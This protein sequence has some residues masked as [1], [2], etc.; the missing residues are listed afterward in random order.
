MAKFK[1]HMKT[2]GTT[3][4]LLLLCYLP[5]KATLYSDKAANLLNTLDSLID[6]YPQIIEQRQS[7]I[8]RI[9]IKP[10]P[11]TLQARYERNKRLFQ[12]YQYFNTDSALIYV[13]ANIAIAQQTGDDNMMNLCRI[14]R[15]YI[16]AIIGQ[17]H[18]SIGEM[19]QID[20]DKL[21][22][23]ML[24]EY[25]GQM[26]LLYSRFAEYTDSGSDKRE[27]YY[28]R[29]HFYVDSTMNVLPHENPYYILYKGLKDLRTGNYSSS[30]VAL[31]VYLETSKT[32]NITNSKL[33]YVLS[34]LYRDNN[35]PDLRL[36][37]LAEAA[38]MDVTLANND[39][40]TLH[41]LATLLNEKGDNERAY[42]Y[43]SLCLEM[44]N[45]M[46]NRVRMVSC[47]STFDAIQQTSLQIKKAKNRQLSWSLWVIGLVSCLLTLTLIYTYRILNQRSRQREELKNLNGLLSASNTE[48]ESANEQLKNKLH[49]ITVLHQQITETNNLLKEANEKLYDQNIIKEEYIGFVLTLCS[50]YISK[51]DRYRKN[52]N[53]KVKTHQY[54]DLLEFT[55]SPILIESELKE[56]YQTFDAIFLHVYPSF[57]S[58]FNSLLQPEQ[59]ITPKE[60]GRL[61][62][63]LRIF[64]LM[65]LGISDSNKIADFFHWSV[66]TVYNK[67]LHTR[68]KAIDRETFN[69]QVRRLGKSQ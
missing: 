20:H 40:N 66:Q 6:N 4:L 48:L 47:L 42:K 28:E 46:N 16:Y 51:L 9:A 39:N 34:L 38:I 64:A 21:T 5:G 31:K 30:I 8:N 56:F 11:N 60:E 19:Q 45:I 13:N 25:L 32:I 43:I 26:S 67:R 36:E 55:N 2:V 49:E 24:I 65:H 68:Q 54:K 41:D 29:E 1:K 17:L 63:E 27:Y 62:T 10:M 15:S 57:V 59:R 33:L 35:Q 37:C 61:N 14:Q 44:A 7:V 53:N 22:G 18:E 23:S 12:E 50:D 58:D 52:I 69:E 3:F